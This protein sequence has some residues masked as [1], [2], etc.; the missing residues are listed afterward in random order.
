MTDTLSD[1]RRADAH[2]RW[3]VAE[4][5]ALRPEAAA[6]LA[7]HAPLGLLASQIRCV[8]REIAGVHNKSNHNP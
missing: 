2:A 4:S 1:L 6:H 3:R 8:L 7:P 5:L